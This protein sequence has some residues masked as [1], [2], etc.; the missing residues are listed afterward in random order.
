MNPKYKLKKKN[1][2][3]VYRLLLTSTNFIYLRGKFCLNTVSFIFSRKTIHQFMN[4]ALLIIK[5][6]YSRPMRLHSC[7]HHPFKF[8]PLLSILEAIKEIKY[9][10]LGKCAYAPEHYSF[11]LIYLLANFSTLAHYF[12]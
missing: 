6:L 10:F 11:Y 7:H 8:F 9:I 5:C 2:F 4:T 3:M 1:F 12:P